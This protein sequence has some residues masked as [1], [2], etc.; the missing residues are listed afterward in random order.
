M[1]TTIRRVLVTGHNGYIG[2][3]LAP[4]LIRAGYDVVGLD[5]EYFG[6]CTLVP[7]LGPVP[8]IRKDIRD[9]TAA[10]LD[11]CDAVVHLAALSNDPLGDLNR[12]WTEEINL[13]ASVRLAQLA[14]AAGV[15][16]FLFSS[17]CI[18][19]GMSE[20]EVVDET[21]PLD[22]RTDYARTKAEAERAIAA[23]T[24][25][26]FAPVFLRNGTVYGLSPRM[27]FDTVLN[28]LVGSAVAT[29]RVVVH[30]DGKP[31][32]PVVH[33]QDVAR[34]FAAVLEAPE[35]AV[36]G[37]V[38]NAG[39]NHLNY[40]VMDLARIVAATVPGAQLEVVAR[41]GADQRTYRADFGKFARTFPDF[42]FRWTPEDGAREL[43]EAF[44]A[45][46][47]GEETFLDRRFTRL[48]WL[49]HLLDSGRLDGTLR[50]ARGRVEA[51]H[52]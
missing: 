30:S 12:A 25:D 46:G 36:R 2:S 24:D 19:Y 22:P 52:D 3:V 27:R 29:G 26:D 9:L 34:L 11:G 33:V 14:R 31:W 48:K 38:F 18:M 45:L 17:S 8:G 50:W 10:D 40:Q 20:A 23:L 16:R 41:P 43:Y 35:E 51:V 28:N 32:R 7:D 44:A 4:Y 6:E 1:A 47:V 49:R 13:A 15:R 37:Q 5:T 39:A 42:R 21:S